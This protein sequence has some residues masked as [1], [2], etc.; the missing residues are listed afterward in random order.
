MCAGTGK[1]GDVR[2]A[3]SMVPLMHKTVDETVDKAVDKTALSMLLSLYSG[4]SRYRIRVQWERG[5][6]L[7]K[8]K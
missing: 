1:Q 6:I 2:H 7:K 8:K 4:P 3:R 5:V